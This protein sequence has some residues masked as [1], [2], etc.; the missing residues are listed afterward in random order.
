LGNGDGTFQNVVVYDSG[1]TPSS[2]A[3]AD[4]NGDGKPDV[5]VANEHIAADTCGGI[6]TSPG[7]VSVLLGNGDG[8]FQTAVTY[9]AGG[10]IAF[11][12]TVGDL[13]GDGKPDLIAATGPPNGEGDGTVSVLIN[14]TMPVDTTPPTITIAATPTTLGPPNGKMVPV[15]VSGTIVDTGSGVNASTAAYSV[16]DEYG[17]V[18]PSG[19]IALG[20][21]GSYSFTVLLQA[22]RSGSDKNGRTFTITVSANDNAGNLGSASTVVTVNHDQGH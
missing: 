14:T 12:V 7:G 5:V 18:Q 15:T 6:N 3:L 17:M 1:Y 13:N 2:V 16:L 20:P 8:T 21:G 19:N 10:N 22:S 11:G 4:L 9:S